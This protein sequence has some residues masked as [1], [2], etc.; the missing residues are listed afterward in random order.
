MR[1]HEIFLNNGNNITNKWIH[2][3]DIYEKHFSRFVDTDVLILE[4][5][6]SKGGS[7]EMWRE[8]FGKNATIVGI[9][10][11]EGC[12][13]YENK[14]KNIFI[15]IG[16]QSDTKF[17]DSVLE[18]YGIPNIV[19]DDGSHVMIDLVTTFNHLYPKLK[20]G[21]VYLAEDLHT[22]YIPQPFGGGL[23]N[24]ST[25]I[26]LTKRNIDDLN[27]GTLVAEANTPIELTDFWATT[28]SITCYDSIHVYEKKNQGRRFSLNTGGAKI[29]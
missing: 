24:P 22:S 18:K 17:I 11:V 12:K 9:D 3:I 27:M 5:G 23:H 10:I 26:E 1:L 21:A 19:I 13:Q 2:Y 16:S 8:Y 25:F 4:I 7:V 15:E 20:D 29:F 6:V 14:N 28:N